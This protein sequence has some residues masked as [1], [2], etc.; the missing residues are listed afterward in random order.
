M[1]DRLR[2]AKHPLTALAGWHGHPVHPAV[3][4]LPVGAWLAGTG[5]DV[6]SRL[7]D[8][9]TFLARGATWLLVAGLFGAALSALVGVLDLAAI[10]TGT[11][12]FR[13]GL[14]HAALVLTASGVFLVDVLLRR[15]ADLSAPTATGPLVLSLVGL[16]VLGVGGAFGGTLVFRYGVRVVEEDT[17]ATG[18]VP[19]RPAASADS[20]HHQ[21]D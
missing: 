8:D 4:H 16:T 20:P 7:V 10:P 15:S 1:D 12:A 17:Q 5:F 14:L 2:Q 18:Y 9:P 11:A 3:V 13:T 6:A 21:G 19:R